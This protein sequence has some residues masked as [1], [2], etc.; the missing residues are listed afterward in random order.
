MKYKGKAV[1]VPEH[2][3]KDMLEGEQHSEQDG[4][5][6]DLKRMMEIMQMRQQEGMTPFTDLLINKADTIDAIAASS[7]TPT[8]KQQLMAPELERY[9][10]LMARSRERQ[11]ANANATLST[12]KNIQELQSQQVAQQQQPA[13]APV[14]PRLLPRPPKT[15]RVPLAAPTPPS[16]T[17][18]PPPGARPKVPKRRSPYMTRGKLI[19]PSETPKASKDKSMKAVSAGHTKRIRDLRKDLAPYDKDIL[20]KTQ[21]GKGAS[22]LSPHWTSVR[23]A[24]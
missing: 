6:V 8:M 19:P 24:R 1:L 11:A 15:P 4:G 3:A 2:L 18:K 7:M 13:Q 22:L 16:A 5:K 9:R 23:F 21:M 10:D 17:P 14:T 12:L 20:K